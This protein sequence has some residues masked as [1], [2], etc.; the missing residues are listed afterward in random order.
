MSILINSNTKVICQGITGQSGLFHV[1][2][3]VKYGT[4]VVAGVTPMKGGLSVN[5]IP[6]FNTVQE[7]I[8]DTEADATIIFVPSAFCFHAILEALDSSLKLIV[9]ITEGIPVKDMI[10]I[11]QR[12]RECKK[13]RDFV[14]IG[15]NCPGVITPGQCKVGIMPGYIHLQN[16]QDAKIGKV[17][18]VSRSGT[19][20]YEAIWQLTSVGIAQST[21]VGIGGDPVLGSNFI[22]ILKMFESDQETSAVLMIGEVGGN[23][24]ELAAEFHSQHMTKPLISL[25]VGKTAPKGKRMGHAGAIVEGKSG[26]AQDKIDTLRKLGGY[27]IDSADQ[28]GSVVLDV[29]KK[30]PL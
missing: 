10:Y 16:S 11:K 26:T 18:V 27:V 15:P 17:G 29:L 13:D 8:E 20:T 12:I 30:Y 3:C 21:V 5:N 6:V 25:I 22:D 14:M 2:Q 28:I 19:L 1:D 4:Q 7:A 23:Q 9:C 24:E